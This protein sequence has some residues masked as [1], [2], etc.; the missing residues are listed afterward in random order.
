MWD[1]SLLF[2]HHK[3]G[4]Y[5]DFNKSLDELIERKFNTVRIDAY[6][7]IIG[8]LDSLNQEITF[9]VNPQYNWGQTDK[10][11]RHKIAVE[12]VEFMKIAKQK[13]LNIILST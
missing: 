6:P 2:M 8:L 4:C 12:L 13:K 1:F 10:N 3:N 9:P 7:L 11:Y 5:E